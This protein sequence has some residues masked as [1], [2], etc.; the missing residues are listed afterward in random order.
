MTSEWVKQKNT[1][2]SRKPILPG[3]WRRRAGGHV[4]RAEVTDPLT[5]KR[6]DIRKTLPLADAA[7]AFTTLQLLIKSVREA[8]SAKEVNSVHARAETR[9]SPKSSLLDELTEFLV[10]VRDRYPA[11]DATIAV[12]LKE[13]IHRGAAC[14]EVRR[15]PVGSDPAR[16]KPAERGGP[17]R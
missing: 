8:S 2:M 14:A 4:I 13:Q 11:V 15:P 17:R 16:P 10:E 6:K 1:W 7:E 9:E 3:V 5:R 12:R